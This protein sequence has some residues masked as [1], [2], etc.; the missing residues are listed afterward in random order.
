MHSAGSRCCRGPE[1]ANAKD[2]DG[3]G[4]D[5]ARCLVGRRLN[6]RVLGTPFNQEATPLAGG[7]GV[8]F[9]GFHNG[10]FEVGMRCE[11]SASAKVTRPWRIVPPPPPRF[12]PASI[13]SLPSPAVGP[14]EAS[15][16]DNAA[17]SPGLFSD[18][19]KQCLAL[20]RG[21]ED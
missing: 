17:S 5:A 7:R 10:L 4:R 2:L 13:N 14:C 6:V 19:G 11:A 1:S 16:R 9:P 3:F 18:F 21:A 15:R 8:R 12:A 20:G